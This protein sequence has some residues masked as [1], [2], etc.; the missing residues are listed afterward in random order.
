MSIPGH[1]AVEVG[2]FSDDGLWWWD[3]TTWIATAQIVLP[4]LPVTAFEQS[5]K[6]KGARSFMRRWS[7]VFWGNTS[8]NLALIFLFPWIA[9]LRDYRSWRLEQL[10]LATAYLLGPHE[11][12]L[13]G[14]TSLWDSRITHGSVRWDLAVSVTA[15]HILV[16]GIDSLDGQPRW[17]ALA[18]RATDVNIELRS[19]VFGLYPALWISCGNGQWRIRG[20]SGVFR[21]EPVLE[22]WR[23]AAT[24]MASNKP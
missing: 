6:L 2:Q 7:L 3:G 23:Q 8:I 16:F 18:A 19:L 11:A 13:A 20:T 9:A 22:A 21:P 4:Q 1:T 15:A 17:V 12:M 14:E 24:R 10:A 5:G